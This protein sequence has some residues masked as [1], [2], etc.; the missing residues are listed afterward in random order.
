[1]E[2]AYLLH[3]RPYRETSAI[4]DLLTIDG[5][6][7]RA[8]VKGLRREAKSAQQLR[9]VLRP[10]QPILVEYRGRGDLKNLFRAEADGFLPE[11]GSKALYSGFYLN[12]L[13][14]KLL[15]DVESYPVFFDR[16]ERALMALAGCGGRQALSADASVTSNAHID[17]AAIAATLRSFEFYLVRVLGY[18]ID[19]FAEADSGDPIEEQALYRF[20]A[21]QGFLRA[22]YRGTGRNDLFTGLE[23][24]A[25]RE[26]HWQSPGISN[27]A[28]ALSRAVI[29]NL[30]GGQQLQ[31]RKLFM[32]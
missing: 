1:M 9:G 22:G 23:V 17:T 10:F 5:G 16:Y 8:V 14:N 32:D 30:L 7:I 20:D 3:S 31:S 12:E 25:I 11:L 6:I 26:S 18:G 21:Q 15:R 4:V 2:K 13:V 19:F 24:I 27:K 28:R 29:D